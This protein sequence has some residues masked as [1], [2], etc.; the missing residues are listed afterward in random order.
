MSHTDT[1]GETSCDGAIIDNAGDGA[2]TITIVRLDIDMSSFH[3]NTVEGDA[4][5]PS[6]GGPSTP[7]EVAI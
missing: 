5:M 3:F 7:L 1:V 6:R 4:R 2:D